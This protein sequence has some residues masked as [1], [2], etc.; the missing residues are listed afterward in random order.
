MVEAV[1]RIAAAAGAT[2][3]ADPFEADA[4]RPEG[5]GLLVRAA[6]WL[7]GMS[8]VASPPL[9]LAGR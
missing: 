4:A 2:C 6:D 9:S 7:E 8:W 3:H 5:R 1:A